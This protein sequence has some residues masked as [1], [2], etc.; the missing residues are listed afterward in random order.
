MPRPKPED[1]LHTLY[2]KD[3]DLTLLVAGL[4]AFR[5]NLGEQR[6][7]DDI[8]ALTAYLK[9]ALAMKTCPNCNA[10]KPE[11]CGCGVC[12]TCCDCDRGGI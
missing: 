2:L 3:R 8:T 12:F 7:L 4:D 11:H 9:T 10:V 1:R 6:P 5:A